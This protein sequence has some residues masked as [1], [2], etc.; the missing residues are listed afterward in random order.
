ML[1][2]GKFAKAG[3]GVREHGEKIR[4]FQAEQTVHMQ[5][6]REISQQNI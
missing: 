1:K 2:A 3:S 5:R 6:S 4:T